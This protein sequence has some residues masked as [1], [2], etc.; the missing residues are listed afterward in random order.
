MSDFMNKVKASYAFLWIETYEEE[1]ALVELVAEAEREGFKTYTWDVARGQSTIYMDQ[2]QMVYGVPVPKSDN[3][4]LHPLRWITSP[5]KTDGTGGPGEQTIVFLKDYHTYLDPKTFPTSDIVIRTIRN[6]LPKLRS[7]CKCLVVLSPVVNIPRELDKEVRVISYKLP[8]RIELKAVLQDIC[9]SAKMTKLPSPALEEELIHAALGMTS[10]EASNAYSGSL[11]EGKGLK[12]EII[13]RE[14][15]DSVRRSGSLEVI[16]V[17]ETLD[18]VGGLEILKADLT[19]CK[20][21]FSMAAHEYGV[22]SPRGMIF[23]GV[24]GCGKSL[25]AKAIAGAF[26]M[27]LFRMDVSKIFGKYVGESE[28]NMAKCLEIAAVNA[29]CILWM[30]ELEKS[31][32]GNRDG[33]EGH[34]TTKK[35]FGMLLNFLQ[36]NKSEVFL[37]ATA[38]SVKALPPELLRSGRIDKLYWVDLPDYIQREEIIKIHL[39]KIGRNPNMFNANMAQLVALCDQFSGADIEQWVQEALKLA[40]ASKHPDLTMQDFINT[41]NEI[42]PTSMMMG[43][44][45]AENREWALSH[46]CKRASPER[47][48]PATPPEARKATRKIVGANTPENN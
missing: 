20:N 16:E 3:D 23:V 13:R 6:S 5:P 17:T 33:D 28:A 38:N 10:N 7:E 24:P 47:N 48:L 29:P 11:S 9:A 18:D 31:M 26:G 27:P 22:R 35:V 1:R 25:L 46:G 2:G 12:P 30:D 41:K 39:R 32:S 21:N 37:A 42:T 43:A 40:Y 34:E 8:T 45:I 44:K 4:P 14:K 36:E 15:S 19:L